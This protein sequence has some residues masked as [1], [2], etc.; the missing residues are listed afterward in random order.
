MSN[1][2]IKMVSSSRGPDGEH[3]QAGE[4]VSVPTATAAELIAYGCAEPVTEKPAPEK[5]EPKK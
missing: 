1:V 4:T 2:L 3:L 5:K